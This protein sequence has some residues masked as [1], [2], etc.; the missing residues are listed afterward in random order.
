MQGD[1]IGKKVGE[2]ANSNMLVMEESAIVAQAAKAMKKKDSSCV[3]VSRKDTKDLV[4][5][6]TERDVLY[7]VVAESIG[8]FKITLNEIMRAP[9]ISID[10]SAT[11]MEAVNL[12][13]KE[14]IRRLAVKRNGEIFGF[15]TLLSVAG[16]VPSQSVGI[17][18]IETSP[19][20]SEIACPYCGSG[21]ESKQDLSK[22]VDRLHIGSGLLEG[23]LRQI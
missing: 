13:R 19:S 10:E 2:L 6:I 15:V 14:G 21:F 11:A 16:N 3:F 18:Q 17:G 8:P 7:R 1:L 22:H 5:I 20:N 4:G 12:M 23:D 9:L